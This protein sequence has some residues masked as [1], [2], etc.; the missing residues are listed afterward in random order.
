VLKY[1]EYV[2]YAPD[3]PGVVRINHTATACNGSSKSL[4]I[5]R[6][7]DGTIHAICFRCGEYGSDNRTLG[8][9]QQIKKRYVGTG[10][11]DETCEGSKTDKR[12]VGK[13]ESDIFKWPIKASHWVWQ[14]GITTEEVRS[15][16]IA[17]SEKQRRVI[18]PIWW[19]G[20]KR[21]YQL[22]KIYDDD[23]GP[24]YITVN[25]GAPGFMSFAT[26]HFYTIVLV[27]DII[28]AIKVGRNFPAIALLS[29]GIT[30]QMKLELSVYNTFFIWLDMDNPQVINNAVK[31][32]KTLGVFG[33]SI[34]ITTPKDPKCYTNTEIA[35]ILYDT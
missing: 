25:G 5:E 28:S 29:A 20:E 21:G 34:L 3:D 19:H 32:L 23:L 11:S 12:D 16:G 8:T 15:Y 6:R 35:K 1:S 24:K 18:L 13:V 9:V 4:R 10:L 17:Y 26:P 30:Q 22:R 27:E 31:L 2:P 14:Y 7:E 33:K